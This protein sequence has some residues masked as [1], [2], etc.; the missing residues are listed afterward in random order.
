MRREMI[1]G[2]VVM[3]ASSMTAGQ[4]I[5]HTHV[6]GVSSVPQSVMDAVGEQKWFF[7]HAS[8]GLNMLQGMSALHS[9]DPVRY[10][11]TATAVG[12]STTDPT[13]AAPPPV[14]TQDGTIYEWPLGNPSW[15]QK[16][17]RFAGSVE[18]SG[19]NSPSVDVCM[20]KLC[21]IDM[22]ANAAVYIATMTALEAAYPDTLFVYMT[23]PL[24]TLDSGLPRDEEML[25][26]TN[27]HHHQY[28]EAVRAHCQ[29]GGGIL[30]DIADIEAYGPDGTYYSFEYSG[31]TY[32]QL[33]FEYAGGLGHLD[34]LGRER[35]ALAWYATAAAA[36]H[37][38]GMPGDTDL[39]GDVDLDDLFAVRNAF[40][41][42][43]GAW[44]HE[45]DTD[46]DGDVDL[47]DLFAVRNNFGAGSAPEP[48]T[49][50]LLTACGT[51]LLLRRRRAKKGR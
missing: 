32:P 12:F 26:Q 4:I 41:T 42:A 37:R 34:G 9:S 18:T 3:I 35:V 38:M 40:G 50:V 16:F 21:F 2:V 14:P 22:D 7:A 15:S 24:V 17:T 47:D 49:A 10:Q 19:W 33:Y 27:V 30:L 45:G 8:V 11:L 36:A 48:A 51:S 43:S 39:D 29:A 44:G 28:N 13:L 1:I 5:G 25:K 31:Q 6:D 46:G 20:D 23:Q